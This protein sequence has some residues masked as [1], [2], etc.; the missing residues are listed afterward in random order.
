[1][2][3]LKWEWNEN[4]SRRNFLPQGLIGTRATLDQP[5]DERPLIVASLNVKGL[6]RNSPKQKEI[7]FW[8]SSWV[9]P[10]LSNTAPIRTPIGGNRLLQFHKR[11]PILEWHFFLELRPTNGALIENERG[12]L[13]SF[14]P[15]ISAN[16]IL[17]EG[18][19]QFIT[20]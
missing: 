12:H 14:A 10:P 17:L 2:Q 18:R 1:L 5:P 3:E 15:L 6:G 9:P 16:D 13:H 4:S 7:R 8:I 19:A 20:L 11:D